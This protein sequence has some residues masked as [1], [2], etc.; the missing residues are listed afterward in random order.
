M[1]RGIFA[2]FSKGK[3]SMKKAKQE[4]DS[5]RSITFFQQRRGQK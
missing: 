4:K 3:R 1:L 2:S 5:I